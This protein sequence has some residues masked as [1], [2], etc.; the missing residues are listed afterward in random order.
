MADR[1]LPQD[2]AEL[3]DVVRADG[4]PAGRAKPRA[5]VHRDGDWH[6]SVH[7]WVAGRGTGPDGDGKPFLLLQRRAAGKDTWPGRLD[8]TVG[9][10][11]RAGEGLAEALRETEEEIGLAVSGPDDPRLRCLGLR[12]CANEAEAGVLDHELQD[13]FLLV[14]DRPLTAFRPHPTELA[15]LVRVAL[16]DLLALLGGERERA[17]A[18]SMAPGGS[19]PVPVELAMEDFIP[20]VDRY[21]YRLAVAAGLVLRGERHVAV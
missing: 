20:T 13:V 11:Y 7:V 3:I 15:A 4:T 17:P 1:S 5:A 16:P 12:V 19:E 9:G 21:F 18:L 14:D 6:R 10:H 2:P 8:A